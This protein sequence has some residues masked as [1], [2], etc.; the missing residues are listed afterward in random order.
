MNFL[1]DDLRKIGVVNRFIVHSER[2]IDRFTDADKAYFL[3]LYGRLSRCSGQNTIDKIAEKTL[4]EL[5]IKGRDGTRCILVKPKTTNAF[6]AE[7]RER[8]YHL[9]GQRPVVARTR[10]VRAAAPA[11]RRTRRVAAAPRGA[12]VV[13]PPVVRTSSLATNIESSSAVEDAVVQ[14]QMNVGEEERIL[15]GDPNIPTPPLSGISSVGSRVGAVQG[16]PREVIDIYQSPPQ[17]PYRRPSPVA[18]VPPPQINHDEIIQVVRNTV[19]ETIREY[20]N[21]ATPVA[22]VVPAVAV[23]GR[24]TMKH[25]RGSQKSKRMS[26]KSYKW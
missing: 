26:N 4:E 16:S 20:I 2:T 13:T 8:G 6:I 22:G 18:V 11:A 1:D 19:Q 7:L 5:K 17:A 23:G 14:H 25:R 21:A 3:E 9:A 10:R 24:R 15:F 12:F